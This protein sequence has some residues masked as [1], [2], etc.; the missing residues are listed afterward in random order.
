MLM[1]LGFSILPFIQNVLIFL[2]ASNSY[3]SP[4]LRDGIHHLEAELAVN[5]QYSYNPSDSI[6]AN[7]ILEV[8]AYWFI[9]HH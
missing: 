6:F 9:S 5:F 3:L 8:S 7:Q 2:S 4:L 1:S